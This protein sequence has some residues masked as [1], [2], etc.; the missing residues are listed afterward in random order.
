MTHLL[1][2]LLALAVG[3]APSPSASTR[4]PSADEPSGGASEPREPETNEPTTDATS[5][6]VVSGPDPG[7]SETVSDP[8]QDPSQDPSEDPSQTV[9]QPNPDPTTSDPSPDELESRPSDSENT[10]PGATPPAGPARSDDATIAAPPDEP[11]GGNAG[12][13]KSDDLSWSIGGR[14]MG[15]WEVERERPVDEP[16]QTKQ[17]PFLRQAR[18]KLRVD[19][20]KRFKIRTSFDL[21]DALDAPNFDRVSY[22]RN[23]YGLVRFHDAARLQFGYFKRPFSRLELRGPGDLPVRGRGLANGRIIEDRNYGDRSVGTMLWGR[24]APARLSWYAGAFAPALRTKGIDVVGRLAADPWPW[25]SI[26]A[27]GSYKRV[28]NGIGEMVDVGS[29]GAD[30][31]VKWKGLYVL[32][33]LVMGQDYLIPGEPFMLGLVGYASYDVD[34]PKKLILQPVALAEWVDSNI[35]V[36]QNDAIRSVLGVNL[37]W[38]KRFRVMP[39]VELIRPRGVIDN[40]WTDQETY[41]VMLS[42]DL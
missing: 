36:S 13:I 20:K 21:A 12:K 42:L 17:E 5:G 23:A 41:Y 9:A 1:S 27:N 31:R 15:G 32:G 10:T 3:P 40:P 26:G 6:E 34:L 38:R 30:F 14:I 2:L 24:I 22:L 16:A 11:K 33:D 7:S 19:Y 39:Q 25:L 37:I 29:F 28:E 8:S 18:V 35:E 4:R